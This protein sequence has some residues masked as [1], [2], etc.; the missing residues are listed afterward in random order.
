M[1]ILILQYARSQTKYVVKN[2]KISVTL[3]D[4]DIWS[5]FQIWA[6]KNLI[7]MSAAVDVAALYI[8]N[9]EREEKVFETAAMYSILQKVTIT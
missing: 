9:K 8:T 5:E 2:Y 4:F 7:L 1:R 6:K 3:L